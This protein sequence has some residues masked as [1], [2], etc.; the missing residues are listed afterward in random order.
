ML[1]RT[2]TVG[3]GSGVIIG[4]GAHIADNR[5]RAAGYVDR[6]LKG[7]NPADMP[8]E[9]PTKF[10]LVINLKLANAIGVT[11]PPALRPYMNGRERIERTA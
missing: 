6:I 2:A 10:D 11:I 3:N 4:Y 1:G 9:V 5:R 8:V 7:A